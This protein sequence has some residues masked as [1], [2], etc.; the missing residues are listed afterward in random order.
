ML[1]E[2]L[3]VEENLSVFYEIK[4]GSQ[5]FGAKQQEIDQIISDVGLCDHRVTVA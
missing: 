1:F 3:T 4:G 2:L 5:A